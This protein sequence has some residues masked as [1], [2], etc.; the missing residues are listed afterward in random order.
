MSE[1]GD[2]EIANFC[3]QRYL[4]TRQQTWKCNVDN[5]RLPA[6]EQ[7]RPLDNVHTTM[8]PENVA[9]GKACG[10]GSYHQ[11]HRPKFDSDR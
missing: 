4:S 2:S 10:Q 7:P 9:V 6:D 3:E 5:E 11:P 1:F 8:L